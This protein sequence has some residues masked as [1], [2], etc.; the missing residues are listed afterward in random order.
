M[1]EFNYQKQAQD[2]YSKAPVIILGSGASAARGMSGMSGL[3][4]HLVARTNISDLSNGE[5]AAWEK[6][7]QI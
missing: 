1:S 7:C 4:K 2:F 5:I 6:F 3:A